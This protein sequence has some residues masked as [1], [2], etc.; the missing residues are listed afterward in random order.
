VTGIPT[1]FVRKE[2]KKYGTCRLAEGADPAE[3]T[4]VL[5]EDVITTGGA[6]LNAASALRAG[7]HRYSRRVRD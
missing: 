7:G 1:L 4:I 6:V 2:A 3:R 5:V